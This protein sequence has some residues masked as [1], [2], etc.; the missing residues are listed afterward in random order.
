M[1]SQLSFWIAVIIP[2]LT[3]PLITWSYWTRLDQRRAELRRILSGETLSSYLAAYGPES[4]D[5]L[6][7]RY[8][9]GRWFILPVLLNMLVV[10]F[11]VATFLLAP[12]LEASN[13]QAIL[14]LMRR[15]PATAVAGFGGAYVWSH[16]DLIKRYG[17]IDLTPPALHNLWLRLIVG[18]LGGWAIGSLTAPLLAVPIAVGVGAFPLATIRE[19]VQKVLSRQLNA[20]IDRTPSEP[21][22]LQNIQG[23][24][25]AVIERL[26]EES[27]D[28]VQHLALSN[29][30]RLL[31]KTTIDWTVLLD[32]I[33]Q[34]YLFIYVGERMAECRKRGYRGAIEVVEIRGYLESKDEGRRQIGTSQLECLAK[35]LGN[36]PPETRKFVDTLYEDPQVQF[37]WNLWTE[38]RTDSSSDGGQ[39]EKANPDPADTQTRSGPVAT[40]ESA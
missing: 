19:G 26:A 36:E 28:S 37:I 39:P 12:D 20:S 21:P 33:D 38:T 40:A 9:D 8:H 27:V 35:V 30:I 13:G 31:L 29:P 1:T 23:A 7:R 22:T 14:E 10:A 24:T 32:M 18:A 3:Y 17:A 2:A 25:D 6:F 16:Y 15:L 4:P 11:F 5:D 34:A